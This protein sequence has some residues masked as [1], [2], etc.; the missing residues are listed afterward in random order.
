[1]NT[2]RPERK[3]RKGFAEGAEKS[4]L[5]FPFCNLCDLCETFAHSAIKEFP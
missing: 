2:G 3:G 1:M 5:G 4:I